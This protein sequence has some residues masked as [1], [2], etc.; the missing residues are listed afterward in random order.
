MLVL[1]GLL[2]WFWDV[3]GGFNRALLCFFL[4]LECCKSGVAVVVALDYVLLVC[5]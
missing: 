3:L 5:S 1:D 2:G 4:I